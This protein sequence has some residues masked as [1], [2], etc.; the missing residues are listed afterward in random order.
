LF[1]NRSPST[2][3][4]FLFAAILLFAS[5]V[6][7]APTSTPATKPSSQASAASKPST[8]PTTQL[9]ERERRRK[10][11]SLMRKSI[12]LLGKKKYEQAESVL[13][14]ALSLDPDEPTNLYNMACLKALIGHKEEALNYLERSADAGFTDFIHI[15]HDTD[16]TSL[17]EQARYKAFIAKKDDYQRKAAEETIKDLKKRFGE[18]YLYEIDT[19]DKLIFATNTDKVTLDALKH[20]L[21][22]QA[23]S[24]WA[25][26]FEHKPDQYIA[27]VVPS[28]QD[29]RKIVQMPG[30][31]GFYN[32]ANRT[33]IAK[34]LGFVTTHEFTHALHAAD[35]DPLGQDHPIWLVEGMAV[36]FERAEFEPTDGSTSGEVPDSIKQADKAAELRE[37]LVPHDNMRL[38]R[39]QA[40][41]R[42][43]QL[44]PLEKMFKMEQPEF[45]AKAEACYAE[46][47]SVMHYL[48]S[49][50]LLREF[51]DEAKKDYDKDKSGRTALEKV[52]GKP[53]AEFEVDWK[54]WMLKRVAPP[55]NTGTDGPYLGVRFGQANDGLQIKT[56]VS[57]PP[58]PAAKAGIKV[59]DVIVGL[60]DLEVRD[61]MTFVPLL[62][63]HK[64]GD[65]VT[66]RI[67]RDG[68]YIQI[69]MILGKRNDPRSGGA[70]SRPS[71]TP[72]HEI[73]PNELIKP[74]PDT[75]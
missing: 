68:K 3:L 53:L 36:L 14:E 15:A 74:R 28:P 27:V 38:F 72:S 33:L 50:G 43:N 23:H 18:D 63:S 61:E 22:R 24:Q 69:A 12:D 31:E 17:H 7:A 58:G 67:R 52:V 71:T 60:D 65:T 39:L 19:T 48:Y 54:N 62:A 37:H 59:G 5:S 41:A 57:T 29:Y 6:V 56:V 64:P 32:H 30:V 40:R 70:A 16:L 11:M 10:L 47:G 46:A 51:Y 8:Q 55:M 42:Q 9:T 49:L 4:A 20:N 35:L 1:V 75:D 2:R 25:E 26:I 21:L 45:V 13:E 34:G 73:P 44:V 66:F